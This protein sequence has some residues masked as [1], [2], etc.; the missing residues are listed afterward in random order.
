MTDR[1]VQAL[2][3]ADKANAGK[4][5]S[6]GE[7]LKRRL[8]QLSAELSTELAPVANRPFIVFH[9]ALQYFEKRFGLKAAGSIAMSPEVAP[10]AKRL[11]TLRKKVVSLGVACV[12][13]EPQ[14]DTRLVNNLTEG[15]KARIGTI[16]PEGAKL[17]AGPG[18]YF[19]L[20]RNL[21]RDLK[22]CLAAP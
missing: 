13:A 19:Q 4:F 12:L 7:D 16:D 20:L 8:D 15:T 9:D 2:S 18:L 6:N 1:I 5:Q 14:F 17:D 11:S 22:A 21:A 3:A 10:S